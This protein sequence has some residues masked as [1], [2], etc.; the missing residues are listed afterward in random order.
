MRRQ[1]G[2]GLVLTLVL[3]AALGAAGL[4][5]V[6]RDDDQLERERRTSEAL[7]QAKAALVGYAV[8]KTLSPGNRFGDLP[9]PDT[10]DDGTSVI[11]ANG[12]P[13]RCGD[14]RARLGRLPWKTLGIPDLRDGDGER[15]WYAV[16]REFKNN[17]RTACTLPTDAGCLNSD[18]RGSITIRSAS[19]AIVHHG[20]NPDPHLP[21]GAIAVVIAPGAAVQ[22]QHSAPA[23]DR[24]ATGRNDPRN[25]LDAAR[26]EDNADF[27]DGSDANGFIAGP[28]R[29]DSG[30]LV[31]NDRL[32]VVAYDDLMPALERRVAGEIARCLDTY[33][34]ANGGRLPFAADIGSSA[35]GAAGGFLDLHAATFGRVADEP[36][37]RT[38]GDS[39][40]TM[41]PA[42][43]GPPC[44]LGGAPAWWTNWKLHVFYRVADAYRPEWPPRRP[45]CGASDCLTATGPELGRPVA[46]VRYAVIVAG[47]RLGAINFGQPRHTPSH[48]ADAA[49]YLEG[50]NASPQLGVVEMRSP[51]SAFNDRGVFR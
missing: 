19:G 35:T 23:Q 8:S 47:R 31:V 37:A 17:P 10:D 18:S 9:C 39:G 20:G 24:S 1:R 48:R 28:V 3:L 29:D 38:H 43:P 22:R 5:A 6:A 42:W 12:A 26:G 46:D 45:N 32:A 11:A 15:L 49:N 30:R 51:N 16:S 7:A 25:Y 40:R 41:S 14:Q 4:I 33:A 44:Q 34:L 2:A 50:R 36:L 27:I 21:S 13:E